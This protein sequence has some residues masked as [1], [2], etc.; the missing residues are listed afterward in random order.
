MT[1][2]RFRNRVATGLLAI[3]W[4]LCIGGVA[5]AADSP[6]ADRVLHFDFP[7]M[8]IGTARNPEGPT[9]TT[10]FYFP[11]GVMAAADVRGGSP[12]TLNVPAVQLGYEEK[13]IDAVVL[14]G[15]SWYGLSAATGVANAIKTLK[16]KQ[17]EDHIAGVLGAIIYDVGGRRFSRVTPDDG[18][19]AKALAAAQP[20][21]FPLGAHGAG[22][23]TMQGYYYAEGHVADRFANWPHSGQGGAFARVGPTRIAV[24][25]VVNAMGTI[26]DRQGRVVRCRRNDARAHCP[27]IAD[28]LASRIAKKTGYGSGKAGPTHNTTIT[29]VVTNQKLSFAE[30]QRMAVQVHT[31]MARAIVPFSTSDD[32]DALFAVTTAE[33]DNPKLKPMDLGVVAAKLAWDAILSSP[34]ELPA[35]P[36]LTKTAADA[37]VLRRHVGDY[38]FADG[39]TLHVRLQGQALV[40]SFTHGIVRYNIFFQ[41][42]HDYALLPAAD[43]QFVVDTPARDVI[44]FDDSGL[45]LNPGSWG[46]TAVRK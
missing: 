24:F 6:G 37:S 21:R 1:R 14:S 30:L 5:H 27:L 15:G 2:L 36:A 16:R 34:P 31:S 33:I 7:G 4:G 28:L 18:L 46:Q 42:H 3:A 9:G 22:S 43:G 23:F 12:G 44:R 32:G 8:L 20:D 25:T 13:F 41:D 26:V 45:V 39:S 11:H 17:G 19:G 35:P 10:V 29:L 40:A 38:A